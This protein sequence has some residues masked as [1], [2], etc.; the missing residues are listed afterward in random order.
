MQQ[1]Q[2]SK[3]SMSA[4]VKNTNIL[5]ADNCH[6][7]EYFLKKYLLYIKLSQVHFQRLIPDMELSLWLRISNTYTVW[8]IALYTINQ[9]LVG[10]PTRY[11]RGIF[12]PLLLPVHVALF[13]LK[14]HL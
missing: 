10:T 9:D 11:I 7:D 3:L 5:L 1:H 4:T 8:N 14:I 13:L 12:R 2:Y 6:S